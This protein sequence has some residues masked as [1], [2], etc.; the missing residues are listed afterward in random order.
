MSSRQGTYLEV[1]LTSAYVFST[2]V[3]LE[4]GPRPLRQLVARLLRD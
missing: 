2:L 4:W 1:L 3:I